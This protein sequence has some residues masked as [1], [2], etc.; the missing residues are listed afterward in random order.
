MDKKTRTSLDEDV[1]ALA[2]ETKAAVAQKTP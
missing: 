1:K 2:K